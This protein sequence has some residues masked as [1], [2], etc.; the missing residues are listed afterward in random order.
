[1]PPLPPV[2]MATLPLRSNGPDVG[3]GAIQFGR[4]ALTN[5]TSSLRT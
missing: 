1:M 5:S 3:I 4:G 2:T